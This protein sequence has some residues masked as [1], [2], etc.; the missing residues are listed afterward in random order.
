MIEQVRGK[1]VAQHMRSDV[2]R[3]TRA[4]DTLLDA[5]P[6]R[7]CGEGC[8]AFGQKNRSRR[9]PGDQLWTPRFKVML[10]SRNRFAAQR[11]DTFLVSFSDI[12]DKPSLEVQLL[13]S[14]IAQFGKA[15]AGSIR[16]LKDRLIAEVLR[17]FG[18]FGGEEL[19]DFRGGQ[20]LGHACPTSRQ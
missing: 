10:K 1:A 3:D 14:H 19:F 2:A 18:G 4:A 20:R 16:Q 12:I 5:Q 6:K 8:S 9:A 7:D 13:K 11:D 17:R 15:Q